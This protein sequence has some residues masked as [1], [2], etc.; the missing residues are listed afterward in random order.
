MSQCVVWIIA[1]CNDNSDDCHSGSVS[2]KFNRIE[3]KVIYCYY[4]GS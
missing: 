4:I 2:E 3:S 1:G